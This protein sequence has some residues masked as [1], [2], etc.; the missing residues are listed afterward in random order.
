M[1]G[2]C[3]CRFKLMTKPLQKMKNEF[4]VGGIGGCQPVKFASEILCINK[5]SLC[6]RTV[7]R[8]WRGEGGDQPEPSYHGVV[9]TEAF[10]EAAFIGR[11]RTVPLRN[12]GANYF[13]NACNELKSKSRVRFE[14]QKIS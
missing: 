14:F 11:A 7:L 4:A 1:E 6:D 5:M 3:H 13:C 10:G 9:Y 12:T 8:C 2:Q